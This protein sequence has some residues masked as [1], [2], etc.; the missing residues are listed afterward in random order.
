MV[1][2]GRVDDVEDVSLYQYTTSGKPCQLELASDMSGIVA[3][4]IKSGAMV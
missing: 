1:L 3:A 4:V 2:D